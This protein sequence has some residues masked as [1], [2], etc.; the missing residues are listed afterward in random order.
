MDGHDGRNGW[1]Q[2][3][4][5]KKKK[6]GAIDVCD[7]EMPRVEAE[8]SKAKRTDRRWKKVNIEA[9]EERRD[10]NASAGKSQLPGSSDRSPLPR[11]ATREKHHGV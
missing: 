6:K 1:F 8:Q 10:I 3:L 11:R 4:S 5:P 9:N 7:V 2:N